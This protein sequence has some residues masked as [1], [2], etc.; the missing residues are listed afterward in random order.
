MRS[1]GEYNTSNL[2]M[3]VPKI[4]KGISKEGFASWSTLFASFALVKGFRTAVTGSNIPNLPTKHPLVEP[5]PAG[6]AD[7]KAVKKVV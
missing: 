7:A 2:P 5:I 1:I 6:V 3:K 4:S